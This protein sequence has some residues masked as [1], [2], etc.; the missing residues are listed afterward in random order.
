MESVMEVLIAEDNPGYRH[1]LQKVLSGW[2]YQVVVACDGVQAWDRLQQSEPPGLA[3]LDWMM[4]GMDGVDIC[5]QVR[6]TP[7]L[8]TIYILLLTAK[9]NKRDIVAG[10]DA[11]ADDYLTK[12]FHDQE[13]RARLQVGVRVTELQRGLA[14][15]IREVEE[16]RE[17]EQRLERLLPICAWCKK[18][19]DD[20]DYWQEL[21]SYFATRSNVRFSHG[22]CPEC[23]GRM[24][25]DVAANG[26]GAP[27]SQQGSTSSKDS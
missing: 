22:I 26:L 27:R 15:R 12:P 8:A 9:D 1:M 11:G 7:H 23:A 13:L 19:R 21:E 5:R 17:R 25:A 20:S 18:I 3:I 4:P 2:G 6:Q 10:L 16:A 24:M 14:N